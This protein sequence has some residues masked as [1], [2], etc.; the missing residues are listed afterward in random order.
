MKE[1]REIRREI[2]QG[3]KAK[4]LLAEPLIKDFFENYRENLVDKLSESNIDP[5]TEKEYVRMLKVCAQFKKSFEKA[6]SKG[7]KA[8]G[9]LEKLLNKAK[10]SV[11]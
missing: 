5:E 7:E 2:T 9:L 1:E 6:I 4:Q 11:A 8:E 3:I 10:G